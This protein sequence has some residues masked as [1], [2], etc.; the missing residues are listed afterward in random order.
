MSATN[1]NNPSQHLASARALLVDLESVVGAPDSDAQVK[2]TV[3]VAQSVLVLAEQV[4]AL[5]VLG[6]AD[7]AALGANGQAAAPQPS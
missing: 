2:A 7:A 1:Q 3:A 4:A 6:G 5:R